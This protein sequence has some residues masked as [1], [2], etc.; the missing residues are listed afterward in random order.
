MS[1]DKK[2]NPEEAVSE[3]HNLLYLNNECLSLVLT[4]NETIRNAL[5][6]VEQLKDGLVSDDE[7]QQGMK[8]AYT[9][10]AAVTMH[11]VGR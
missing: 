5:V 9:A 4:A 10:E 8:L 3:L 6:L 2:F 11:G 7:F 1:E